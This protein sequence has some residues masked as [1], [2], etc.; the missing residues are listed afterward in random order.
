[1]FEKF[2]AIH[3][4]DSNYNISPSIEKNLN[5]NFLNGST[6]EAIVYKLT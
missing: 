6:T 2:L 4:P 3:N 5:L 1:M